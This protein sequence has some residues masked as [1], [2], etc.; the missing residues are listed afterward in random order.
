MQLLKQAYV[1]QGMYILLLMNT[2]VVLSAYLLANRV[3]KIADK[4]GFLIAVFILYLSQIVISELILGIF[5]RLYL[6]N[7]L[8]FNAA[9]LLLVWYKTKGIKP[10][11]HSKISMEFASNK[12]ALFLFSI[13]IVFGLVK[14]GIN[15]VNPPFGWDSL[16][17]HFTF[18]VEWLKH[19][20]LDIPITVFD[21]PSP[22]YY[23]INGS[24]FYFWLILPFKNVF[25]ADL[26]QVPFFILCLLAVYGIA[27]KTGVDKIRAFYCAALFFII[28][29]FFKQLSIAYVDVMVAGLFLVCLYYL[30]ILAEEFS[31][32]HVLLYGLSL[33]LLLG[34]KT[35]ALPYS[36]LLFLPFVY[37]C[38]KNYHKSYLLW[39]S[40]FLI[41]IFGGFSYIRN[42]IQTGNPLYPLDFSLFGRVI[43]KGVMSPVIYRAHFK[44]EDYSLAKVL[45]H[46]G[47]GGQSL[48]F[49]LPGIFLALPLLF[50]RKKKR[51]FISAYF[52]ILPVLLYL[53]YRYIIPLANVRYLYA[54]LGMGMVA[55]FYVFNSL[56]IPRKLVNLLVV[57]C[58]VASMSEL[59]K[60]QELVVCIILTFVAF[61][62][63]LYLKGLLRRFAPRN[64]IVRRF[65]IPVLI[66]LFFSL[67]FLEK[68]YLKNEFPRYKKMV[69]YSGF[70]PDAT[71]AWIWLN[72]NTNASNIA[73]AGRPVPF[74]LYGSS[75]KNNV[76]YVSLN[77]VDPAK[78][79]YFPQSRYQWGYD[80]LSQ[81]RNFEAKGNYRA[82]A[83]YATWLENLRRRDTDYLFI[84]SLHQIKGIAFPLEDSWAKEHGEKFKP[85]FTNDTMHI[86][87]VIK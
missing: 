52:F 68:Y 9:I 70:W 13:I 57:L 54:L 10:A 12:I 7:L 32:R 53:V 17:Y 29:N 85:V 48:V 59:A 21:D 3:F 83:D 63:L 25:L 20:N 76:Y 86:Y 15:L 36:F 49:I 22:S 31:F 28:P 19:G 14:I 27:R 40:L 47:L 23:P 65:S 11:G 5:S 39:F 45:F 1:M 81:H 62:L 61:F 56:K 2:M 6:N 8:M 42:F 75:F 30:F 4:I 77:K 80:F 38:L 71:K 73:Y 50:I 72:D 64:D 26:G 35:I 55:G 66:M 16:N 24:L 69:K 44:P 79:H 18:A 78:L 43:F 84:Y 37:L 74:P 67:T 51:G 58:A 46:E 34:I 41:I 87:K 82:E 33:G 60:R